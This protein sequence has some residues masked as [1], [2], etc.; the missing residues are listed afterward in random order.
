MRLSMLIVTASILLVPTSSAAQAPPG[1]AVHVS[2]SFF[3][4]DLAGV[5]AHV[6]LSP[7]LSVVALGH[8]RGRRV[9]CVRGGQ[10][11]ELPPF[12]VPCGVEG[13]GLGGGVRLT[14]NPRSVAQVFLQLDAGAHWYSVGHYREPFVGSRV[15]LG[16]RLGTRVWVGASLRW[17]RVSGYSRTDRNLLTGRAVPRSFSARDAW[18]LGVTLG[19]LSR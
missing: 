1:M 7:R 11:Q 8:A 16:R 14:L 3:T 17:Y 6:P 2:T 5:Q 19:L 18:D 9:E 4:W 13:H 10:V 12:H 15:G